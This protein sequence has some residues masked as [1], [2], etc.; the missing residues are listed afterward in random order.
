MRHC[1]GHD[2]YNNHILTKKGGEITHRQ[3]NKKEHHLAGKGKINQITD[4]QY[5]NEIQ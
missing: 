4:G 3:I 5:Q 2:Q 1:H